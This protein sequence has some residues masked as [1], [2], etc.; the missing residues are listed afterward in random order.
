MRLSEL[1]LMNPVELQKKLLAAAHAHPPD[2]A[3]PYAFE[4]RVMARVRMM[5]RVADRWT[6]WAGALWRA[7]A[8]AVGVMVLVGVCTV[9]L[10]HHNNAADTQTA[11]L[12]TTLYAGLGN[13]G[14]TW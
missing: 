9:I 8:P 4:K 3:V 14:D 10:N 5:G 7:A 12:E 2:D 1:G 13:V 6:V 11:D